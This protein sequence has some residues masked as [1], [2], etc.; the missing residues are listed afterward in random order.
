MSE[1]GTFLFEA[2]CVVGGAARISGSSGGTFCKDEYTAVH[3]WLAP[4]SSFLLC[5]FVW[6]PVCHVNRLPE[7]FSLHGGMPINE[8]I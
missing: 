8:G 6:L 3:C 7:G 1:E 5:F 2:K 4:D